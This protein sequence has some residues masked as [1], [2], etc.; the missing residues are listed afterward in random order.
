M[1]HELKDNLVPGLRIIKTVIAVFICLS[2]FELFNYDGPIYAAIACVLT[3]KTTVGESRRAGFDRI[4]GT[5]LGGI[6]SALLL[7]L[8]LEGIFQPLVISFGILLALMICKIF[9]LRDPVYSMASIV[10]II[11]V[12]SH[13]SS[14]MTALAYVFTRV[15]E[16]MVGIIIATLI[17]RFLSFDMFTKAS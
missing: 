10:V 16:T 7:I 13:G 15:I 12:L 2:F 3:M 6:I 14:T 5:I 11:T 17:N 1:S 4:L 9:K 8:P